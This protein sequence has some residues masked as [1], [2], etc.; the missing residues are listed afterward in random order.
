[1]L[2][3]GDALFGLLRGALLAVDRQRFFTAGR[4]RALNIFFEPSSHAD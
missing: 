4:L 2:H 3:D 1:V